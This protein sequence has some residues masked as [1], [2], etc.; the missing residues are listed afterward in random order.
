[1]IDAAVAAVVP[2]HGKTIEG[3]ARQIVTRA[4]VGE[5][6]RGDN[7]MQAELQFALF[8]PRETRGIEKERRRVFGLRGAPGEGEPEAANAL[9]V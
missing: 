9:F 5:L 6:G 2:R 8:K 3:R 7:C 4:P 1:M